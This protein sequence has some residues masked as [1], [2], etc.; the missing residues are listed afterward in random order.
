MTKQESADNETE[1]GSEEEGEERHSEGEQRTKY[2]RVRKGEGLRRRG[3]KG[4]IN[5]GEDEIERG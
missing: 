5:E 3:G 1:R 4:E 2:V